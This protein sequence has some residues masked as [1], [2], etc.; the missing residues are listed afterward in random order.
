MKREP[1]I[2]LAVFVAALLI[3]SLGAPATHFADDAFTMGYRVGSAIGE[4]VRDMGYAAIGLVLF[5]ALDRRR[6]ER[7]TTEGTL[8]AR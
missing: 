7:A 5:R 2:L 1:L 8:G 4:A 3:H 6:T